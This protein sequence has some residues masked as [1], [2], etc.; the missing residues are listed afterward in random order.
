M[1]RHPRLIIPDI[2]VHIVQ[3]GNDRQG[4]FRG[5]TDYTVYLAMLRDVSAQRQCALH[6]YCL[7]TNHIHLLM[8]PP[9]GRA[10]ALLMRDLGRCYARYFNRR[11]GRTGT[12][13]EGRFRSC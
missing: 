12:L 11:Y 4:C 9:D 6:A 2:A 7:M 13:W 10:C 3:R 5:E 1:A 8:T